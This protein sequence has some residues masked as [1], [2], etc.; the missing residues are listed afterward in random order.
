MILIIEGARNAFPP[1]YNYFCQ[2]LVMVDVIFAELDLCNCRC[3]YLMTHVQFNAFLLV[4]SNLE[5]EMPHKH[6]QNCHD[7][8]RVRGGVVL[9]HY[10]DKGAL[11]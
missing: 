8:I 5:C 11:F 3:S 10:F 7:Y 4:T 9:Y 2:Y 1:P 6:L